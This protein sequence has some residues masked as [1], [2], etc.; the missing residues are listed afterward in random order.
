MKDWHAEQVIPV[1]GM[2]V[3]TGEAGD[4]SAAAPS[5]P[6]IFNASDIAS[7]SCLLNLC[8][9]ADA[10]DSGSD[11]FGTHPAWVE[12]HIRRAHPDRPHLNSLDALQCSGNTANA[13]PAMHSFNRQRQRIRHDLSSPLAI[14]AYTP[15]GYSSI[16][17]QPPATKDRM[18]RAPS[19]TLHLKHY[20][21]TLALALWIETG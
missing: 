21:H 14:D 4:T 19:T 1:T 2:V 5:V 6:S 13:A 18:P 11:L 9:K 15:P 20:F 17:L 16:L 10:T 8:G 3:R 7:S 12:G